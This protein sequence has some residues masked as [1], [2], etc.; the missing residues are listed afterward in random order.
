MDIFV[1]RVMRRSEVWLR[2]MKALYPSL[3][4]QTNV[5]AAKAQFG[6]WVIFAKQKNFIKVRVIYMDQRYSG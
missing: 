2:A 4:R 5:A 3:Q 6:D 1:G